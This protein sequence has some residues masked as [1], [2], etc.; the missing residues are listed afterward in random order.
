MKARTTYTFLILG[1]FLMLNGEK[2]Q[3][4]AIA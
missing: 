1:I 4:T 2:S 3:R